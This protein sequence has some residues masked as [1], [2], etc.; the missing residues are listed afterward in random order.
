MFPALLTTKTEHQNKLNLEPVFR[1]C[2][3][4]KNLTMNSKN[5][6]K[7]FYPII[8][9]LLKYYI[10]NIIT[11]NKAYFTQLINEMHIFFF[12]ILLNIF[13]MCILEYILNIVAEI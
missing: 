9:H 5:K 6:N 1:N 2:Y 4:T 13:F 3:T 8:Y 12:V 10:I 7:E 11:R